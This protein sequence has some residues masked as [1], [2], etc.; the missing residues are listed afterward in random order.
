MKKALLAIHH[1]LRKFYLLI[2][3]LVFWEIAPRIGIF[4]AH[5]I[6][7]ISKIIA[8]IKIETPQNVISDIITSLG[9]ILTGFALAFVVA[10][11]VGFALG[12][13][14]T[15]TKFFSP[16][17]T[18]LS[19][20]PPFI[21]YPV[22]MVI[23][24]V[25]NA[26]VFIVIFWS[27]FWPILFSTINGVAQVDRQLVKLSNS[28]SANTSQLFFKIVL[29]S[30]LP[31]IMTGVRS[32]LTMAFLML[33]GAESMGASSGLG[34]LLHTSQAM[35]NVTRTFLA[36]V[37]IALLGLAINYFVEYLEKNIIIWKQDASGD[38]I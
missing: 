27:S 36:L 37:L 38:I 24:G 5:F 32:G 22:F 35:G 20:I 34:N 15:I 8:Y 11:P 33:I 12:V 2:A 31:S 13:S 16:L 26:G 9:R 21:L 30:A 4:D 28:M 23:F 19:S 17:F 7:P 1:S 14:K 10:V 29:P 3:F 6:P 25:G 18:F